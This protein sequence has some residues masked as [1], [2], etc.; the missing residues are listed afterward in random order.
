MTLT[1]REGSLDWS[2]PEPGLVK[3]PVLLQPGWGGLVLLWPERCSCGR[4]CSVMTQGSCLRLDDPLAACLTPIFP[5]FIFHG[6]PPSC[7][8]QAYSS[9][10]S[11]LLSVPRGQCQRTEVLWSLQLEELSAPPF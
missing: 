7:E 9:W 8:D 1:H 4:P 6:R 10:P 11:G 2:C 5:V 3:Q